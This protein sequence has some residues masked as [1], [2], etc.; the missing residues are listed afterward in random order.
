MADRP[1]TAVTGGRDLPILM[2]ASMVLATI[3]ECEK[4]GTGKTQTRRT[5]ASA[6]AEP[7][8]IHY[9]HADGRRQWVGPNGYPSMPCTL[10]FAKGQR[11]WVRE[12]WRAGKSLNEAK[13]K[14]IATMCQVAGWRRPWCPIK[15]EA[16]GLTDN[17][18]ALNSFGGEWGKTRVAIHMPRWASRL[19]LT[20]TD[21]RVERLQDISPCDA[22]AEGMVDRGRTD[23]EPCAH[24]YVPGTDLPTEHLPEVV[25]ASLWERIN[26]AGAWDA[27]PWIVAVT[28][29]P[30]LR[31]IDAQE[32][33]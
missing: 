14:K 27:N 12:T 15:Y 16:D 10:R 28:Y 8:W 2:S 21:V 6:P 32:R 26:G 13:P 19:T 29:R 7:G 5:L 31:N 17:G 4:P 20:V 23:G 30:E 1:T 25:Y 18:D 9:V 24:Y 3:R 22:L 11:L 33:T